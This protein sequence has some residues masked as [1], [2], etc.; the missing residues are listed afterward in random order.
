MKM[1]LRDAFATIQGDKTEYE[2]PSNGVVII[3]DDGQ[4][5]FS[6]M[7]QKDGSIRV[8]AASPCVHGGVLLDDRLDIRPVASNSINIC[9]PIYR[10]HQAK[11]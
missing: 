5:L 10:A 11:I 2:M 6:V 1:K 3:A 7:M 4:E 9:R 8:S